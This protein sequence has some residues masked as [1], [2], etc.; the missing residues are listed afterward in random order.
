MNKKQ[1]LRL[2]EAY[3]RKRLINKVSERTRKAIL[4][5]SGV[6]KVRWD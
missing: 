2:L 1:A 4:Q 5:S 3:M 6:I